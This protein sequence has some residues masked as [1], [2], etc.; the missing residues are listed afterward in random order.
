MRVCHFTSELSLIVSHLGCIECTS[1]LKKMFTI[2]KTIEVL[3]YHASNVIMHINE[4]LTCMLTRHCGNLDLRRNRVCEVGY[5]HK[6]KVMGN[7]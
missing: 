2:Y 5:K 4:T 7:A 6:R 3:T 1:G